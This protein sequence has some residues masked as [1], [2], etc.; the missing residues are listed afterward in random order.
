M[1]AQVHPFLHGGGQVADLIA[2]F[3]WS[4]TALGPIEGWPDHVK[5]A[6]ALML[7]SN[8]PMVM[9]WG[10]PGVMIYNDAYSHF[11]GKRHPRLLGSDVRDGWPEVADFNDHVMRTVLK[12]ETLRFQNQELTLHRNNRAEQVWMNLDYSPVL[13]MQGQPVGVIAIV[14]ETSACTSPL[15]STTMAITPTG[16]PCMSS[17]GE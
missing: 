2:R 7:R 13:D 14:V 8:V 6:T 4:R 1:H 9:L 16:C 3:D 11:A 15:V 10:E 5:L 17:T 12:G